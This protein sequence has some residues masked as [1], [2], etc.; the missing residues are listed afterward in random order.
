MTLFALQHTLLDQILS[1]M[2]DLTSVFYENFDISY[3]KFLYDRFWIRNIKIFV[4]GGHKYS[5]VSV[6][7]YLQRNRNKAD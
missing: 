1:D 2:V 5:D 3:P 4:E 7:V 6:L